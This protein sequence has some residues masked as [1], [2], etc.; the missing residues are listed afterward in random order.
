MANKSIKCSISLLFRKMQIKTTVRCLFTLT[1]MAIIRKTDVWKGVWRNWSSHSL[2]MEMQNDTATLENSL[3][4]PQMLKHKVTIW[5][6]NSTSR[7][8]ARK[9]ENTCS[10][11]NLYV[12]V[13]SSIIYK[14]QKG[15]LKCFQLMD[16]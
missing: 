2:L 6:I 13:H 15:K 3:V 8:I 4:V 1:R 7:Y 14:T 16:G 9:I 11:K 5:L 10:H 12:D